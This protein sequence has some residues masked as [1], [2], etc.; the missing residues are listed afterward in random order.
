MLQPYF[1]FVN[2]FF[3]IWCYNLHMEDFEPQPKKKRIW[4]RLILI[5]LLLAL[6]ALAVF[7]LARNQE[8]LLAAST[9]APPAHTPE[10]AAVDPAF[11]GLTVCFIDVGQGDCI[12]FRGPDGKTMLIDSGPA[13]SFS[14]IRAHLDA[15]QADSLD[16]LVAT[17]LHAD[18]IGSMAEI[19][20]HYA[21]GSFYM[22]PY[23]FESSTYAHLLEALEQTSLTPVTLYADASASISFSEGCEVRVLSPFDAPY[24]DYNDTSFILRVS[25]GENAVLCA[26]DAGEVAERFMIKAFKNH[27]LRADI[28]KVGHHG[29]ENATSGKLLD[30]VRPSVAVIS[31]GADNDYGLPDESVLSRLS[32]RGITIYRTDTDGT[33]CF[34]L[35]GTGLRMLE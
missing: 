35:D 1:P 6:L 8:A 32:A 4:P 17:H 2:T 29:S 18:H 24:T 27:Q 7:L 22:P 16:V 34:A 33:L 21:V 3:F 26:G 19:L 9:P 23:D 28:L 5:A 31:V 14:T 12:F 10:I 25:F 11:E 15:W 13:G 30:A 20:Q